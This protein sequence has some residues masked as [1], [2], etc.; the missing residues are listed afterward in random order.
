MKQSS[1]AFL[2]VILWLLFASSILAYY[3]LE[4]AFGQV[5]VFVSVFTYLLYESLFR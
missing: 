3:V 2:I 1:K 5:L 4:I